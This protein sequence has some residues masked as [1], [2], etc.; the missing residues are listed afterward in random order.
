MSGP[1]LLILRLL[2]VLALYAFVGWALLTVW[3]DIRRQGDLI[4][5]RQVPLIELRRKD[6]EHSQSYR[7]ILPEIV[8]G[9]EPACDFYLDDQTI[10]ARHARLSHHHGQWWIEDL[11]STNGT[12]LNQ[13]TITTPMVIVSGDELCFGQVIVLVS[14]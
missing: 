4:V 9:R 6:Q 7:G 5:M 10:S 1:I 8:I 13:A 12:F 3:R 2:M 11:G 14:M